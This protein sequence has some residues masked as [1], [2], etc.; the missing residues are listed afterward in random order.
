MKEHFEQKGMELLTWL[1]E[2]IKSGAAFAGN[3]IP[4]FIQDLLRYNFWT[5][6]IMFSVGFVWAVF[7]LGLVWKSFFSKN[8]I[9][10]SDDDFGKGLVVFF[11]LLLGSVFSPMIMTKNTDWFKI[12]VA[13]RVYL[14]DYMKDQ[15]KSVKSDKN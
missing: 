8:S 6:L 11:M 4:L 7:T 1:E 15:I 9:E 10:F 5:S 13:P 3:Q 12:S 2:S 14:V